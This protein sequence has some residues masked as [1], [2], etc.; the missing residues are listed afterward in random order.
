MLQVGA[1]ELG[2]FSALVLLALPS[3]LAAA[4][5]VQPVLLKTLDRSCLEKGARANLVCLSTGES[6]QLGFQ[7][8]SFHL[9]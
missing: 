1:S 2:L 4:P 5:H 8:F 7:Q 6:S 3:P 9:L